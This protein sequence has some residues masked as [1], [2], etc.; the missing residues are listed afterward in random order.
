MQAESRPIISAGSCDVAKSNR[1]VVEP[2]AGPAAAAE[3]ASPR[4]RAKVSVQPAAC[5]NIEHVVRCVV[6]KINGR[7]RSVAL[8]EFGR[9]N[10]TG[11]LLGG[12]FKELN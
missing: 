5:G 3:P 7:R 10:A 2:A 1:S 11:R 6:Q 9:G 12:G 8:F 4:Q